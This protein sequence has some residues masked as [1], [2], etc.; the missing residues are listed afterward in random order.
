MQVLFIQKQKM[1]ASSGLMQ[2]TVSGQ[3]RQSQLFQYGEKSFAPV[4]CHDILLT[5]KGEPG[6]LSKNNSGK[7]PS[8]LCLCRNVCFWHETCKNK[9]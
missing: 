4:N 3:Q 6:G 1:V 7:V 9:L 2:D 8:L 5:Y